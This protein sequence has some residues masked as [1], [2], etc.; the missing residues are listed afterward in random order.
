MLLPL[1]LN[2]LLTSSGGATNYTLTC[3][4]GTYTLTGQTASF[5]RGYSLSCV[6]GTYTYT[7]QAAAFKRG[8]SLSAA[9]G[10]YSL[11]GI[12]ATLVY[13]PG[14]GSVAYTLSCAFG[15]YVVT[16]QAATFN[17]GFSL[18]A[19]NGTYSVTGQNA[20]FKRGY[21]LSSANGSYTYTGITA[22]LVYT[23]GA[24]FGY[25]LPSQVQWGV[26]YGPTGVEYTG[27]FIGNTT[28]E[29]ETGRLVKPL[30]PK[31]SLLL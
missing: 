17:R 19:N 29:L 8:Y 4:V 11:T 13:T 12:A 16:G 25:P 1:L 20:A 26:Q 27:T 14:A 30:T 22:T 2:N 9:N 24:A 21:F 31:L 23:P 5:K 15:S 28:L 6:N 18:S 7:G 10:S 3:A